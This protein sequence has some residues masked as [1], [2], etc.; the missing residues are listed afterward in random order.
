MRDV[1]ESSLDALRTADETSEGTDLP[2]AIPLQRLSWV[3]LDSVFDPDQD[4]SQW[5]DI[6]DGNDFGPVD[7]E[8]DD[9]SDW[10]EKPELLLENITGLGAEELMLLQEELVAKA[11]RE[12]EAMGLGFSPLISV[13]ILNFTVL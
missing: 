11:R 5:I 3:S 12:R 6:L 1:V 10:P 13:R 2:S 9:I 4:A 8:P 7:S